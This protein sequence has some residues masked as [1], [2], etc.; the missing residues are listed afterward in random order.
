ML[1]FPFFAGQRVRDMLLLLSRMQ[2][3]D[4][5]DRAVIEEHVREI[6]RDVANN[7]GREYRVAWIGALLIAVAFI[8]R[9]TATLAS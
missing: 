4:E 1:A 3:P 8:A 2:I 9:F 5:Q 7:M 6:R